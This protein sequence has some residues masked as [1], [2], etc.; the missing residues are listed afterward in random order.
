MINRIQIDWETLNTQKIKTVFYSER[1]GYG[2][3]TDYGTRIRF[4]CH[5]PIQRKNR[6]KKS[7][8]L[9]PELCTN[10]DFIDS[11]GV[12]LDSTRF[13]VDDNTIFGDNFNYWYWGESGEEL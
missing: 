6:T 1:V 8:T 2:G 9:E 3:G 5:K 10:W 13:Y 11:F 7:K 12:R 4:K